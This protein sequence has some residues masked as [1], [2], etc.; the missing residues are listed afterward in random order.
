[1][2]NWE[3]SFYSG[4][5]FM[6]LGAAF[7]WGFGGA[8]FAIGLSIMLAIPFFAPNLDGERYGERTKK[9]E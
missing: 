5:V 3:K 4:A 8:L 9:P 7:A 2:N 1:M 6:S